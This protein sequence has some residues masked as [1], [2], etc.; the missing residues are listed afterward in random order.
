[1]AVVVEHSTKK[2]TKDNG[3]YYTK[4]VFFNVNTYH[5]VQMVVR[6]IVTLQKRTGK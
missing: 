1:M 4:T 6:E 5:L 3:F 2:A